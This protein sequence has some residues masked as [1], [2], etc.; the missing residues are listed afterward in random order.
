VTNEDAHVAFPEIHP[1]SLRMAMDLAM[2]QSQTIY[3]PLWE[4]DF[5]KSLLSDK[6]LTQSGLFSPELL[7]NLERVTKLKDMITRKT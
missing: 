6:I 4:K 5:L 1:K 7:R 2:S 3:K